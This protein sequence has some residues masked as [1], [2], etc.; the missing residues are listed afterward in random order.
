MKKPALRGK[1]VSSLLQV[2]IFV[3]VVATIV[4][5]ILG[6]S[7]SPHPLPSMEV[8]LVVEAVMLVLL[9]VLTID[10]TEHYGLGEDPEDVRLT[11]YKGTNRIIHQFLKLPLY[12]LPLAAII[13][14]AVVLKEN[15]SAAA[16]AAAGAAVLFVN[17]GIGVLAAYAPAK[18]ESLLMQLAKFG[19]KRLL[20]F[21][22]SKS[23][24]VARVITA[25]LITWAYYHTASPGCAFPGMRN[26]TRSPWSR[27]GR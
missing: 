3:L 12:L 23:I 8:G 9:F 17:I 14:L 24:T 26:Q 18:L 25:A 19:G 7:G 21:L 15:A 16:G 2:L 13:G 1:K 4:N 11:K 10:R 6:F 27:S 20:A 5:P 22:K